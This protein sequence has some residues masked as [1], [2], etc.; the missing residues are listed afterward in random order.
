MVRKT[1][2]YVSFQGRSDVSFTQGNR[3]TPTPNIDRFAWDGIILNRHYSN[4]ACT[5]TRVELLT[6]KY[7]FRVGKHFPLTT[8]SASCSKKQY[9]QKQKKNTHLLFINSSLLVHFMCQHP[10]YTAEMWV[11]VISSS[12][13]FFVF[14]V[15][16]R[17]S[18]KE[19]RRAFRCSFP[20]RPIYSSNWVIKHGTL[21]RYWL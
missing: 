14:Q 6:G 1:V 13:V 21:E 2:D 15:W 17:R 11:I 3:Q 9:C 19:N 7:A 18:R 5:P 16:Q 8:L 4:R 20:R 12:N 10:C